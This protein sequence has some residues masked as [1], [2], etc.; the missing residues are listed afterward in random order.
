MSICNAVGELFHEDSDIE[1]GLD[2]GTLFFTSY[3]K[4]GTV[5][6]NMLTGRDES[7][8]EFTHIANN[9]IVKDFIKNYCKEKS[10]EEI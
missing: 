10:P 9:L 3:I 6:F 2:D 8:L 5:L 4:A 7:S 1:I